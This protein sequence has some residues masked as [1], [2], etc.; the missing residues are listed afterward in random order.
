ML[1]LPKTFRGRF[2]AD[3]FPMVE[4]IPSIRSMKLIDGWRHCKR[5]V[6]DKMIVS[7][8]T[9]TLF[10][11]QWILKEPI[12]GQFKMPQVE[13]YNGSS[14][15]LDQLESYKLVMILQGASDALLYLAL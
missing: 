10:F 5:D 9:R 12:L 6:K 4:C 15:L 7:A 8:S 1:T 14:D 13:P 3:I 2:D 11:S